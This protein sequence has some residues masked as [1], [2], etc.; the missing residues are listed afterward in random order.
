VEVWPSGEGI[1]FIGSSQL[2]DKVKVVVHQFWEGVGY[3]PVDTLWITVV[4]KVFVV[5]EDGDWVWG[6]C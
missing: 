3:M 6:A 5:V 1:C 4:L 2:V